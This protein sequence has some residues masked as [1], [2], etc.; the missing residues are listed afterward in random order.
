MHVVQVNAAHADDLRDPQV[1]LARYPTVGDWGAAL[2]T[3]GATRVSVVQLFPHDAD[4]AFEGVSAYFRH[5]GGTGWPRP[6]RRL[7]RLAAVA[8]AL[9]PDVVHLNGLIFPALAWELRRVLPPRVALVVQDHASARP[10]RGRLRRLA[11]RWAWHGVDAFLFTAAAQA[12]AWREAGCM[13]A[14]QTVALVPEA[15]RRLTPV[16]RHEARARA[17]LPGWPA[18]LWV[19]HLDANKDPLTVLSAF[20][21]LLTRYPD[22][23]LTLVYRDAPLL[24]RVQALLAEDAHLAARVCLRG[25][26]PPEEVVLLASA[27]DV[28]VL[29]SRREGSGYALIEA[30]ACGAVPVVS[31]IP[32]SQALTD[33]GAVGALFTPGDIDACAQAWQRTVA[34]LGPNTPTR[35]RAHFEARLSWHAVAA[36]AMQAYRRA[37]AAREGGR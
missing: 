24:P 10:P 22:A 23:S 11:W 27:A 37:L 34:A 17:G 14:R 7:R 21:R 3:A 5:D 4:L 2:L 28:F 9:A 19:G 13:A 31:A 30:M 18:C 15:S 26:L 25:A 35:V 12:V 1:L 33:A 29:G 16:P 6:W 8:A 36:Q 20:A 32:A